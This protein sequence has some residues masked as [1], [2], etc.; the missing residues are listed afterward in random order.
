MLRN[1]RR[2]VQGGVAVSLPTRGRWYDAAATGLALTQ[3][4]RKLAFSSKLT[5]GVGQLAEGLKNTSFGLFLLFFYNQVLGVSGT[6]CGLA[7]FIA[8]LFDAV[9]D[10]VAGSLSDSWRSRWGRRHPFMYVSAVPLAIAYSLL[11]APPAFGEIGLFI[12]LTAF[13]VLTR[14]AMTLYHVPH[15]ALGAELTENFEE[16]TSIVGYRT[17]FGVLGGL[18]AASV[19]LGIYFA[20]TPEFPNGQLNAAQYPPYAL[21]LAGGMVVTIWASALGTQKEIPFLPRPADRGEPFSFMRVARETGEALRNASFRWLFAGVIIVFVMVGVD[22]SLNLY[23]NTFFWELSP[24][25]ILLITIAAQIGI[26]CGTPLT[27]YLHRF[28]DKKPAVVWGTAWWA[29]WQIIPVGLRLLDLFPENGTSTLIWTL[30]VIRFIQGAGVVQALV[31]FGSMMADVVDEHELNTG[32]RQEGIFF[33]AVSFSNKAAS[34]F[35]SAIAGIGLDV[36]RW[37]TG[38]NIRTAADIPPET[39]TNLGIFFGPCVAGFAVVSVWCYGHYKLDRQRH[40]EIL[41]ELRTLR[42]ERETGALSTR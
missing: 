34:G 18:T 30:F 1:G 5:Y 8:L 25:W 36:I 22:G 27:R 9:S 17:A 2:G 4:D 19:G 7:L 15:I 10:P 14:A 32:R 3:N 23:M 24:T 13:A 35:G 29:F 38:E 33:G 16:R 21:L 28:F 11:F 12:W 6:L 20:A 42:A 41:D 31:S 39:I 40:Q 37:P 26:V